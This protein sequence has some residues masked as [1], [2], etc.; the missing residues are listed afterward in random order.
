MPV[1]ADLNLRETCF[2][3]RYQGTDTGPIDYEL[4]QEAL[5]EVEEPFE[6]PSRSLSDFEPPLFPR[7]AA[8]FQLKQ[9]G[10]AKGSAPS[11]RPPLNSSG[12]VARLGSS[13]RHSKTPSL[14]ESASSTARPHSAAPPSRLHSRTTSAASISTRLAPKPVIKRQA[15]PLADFRLPIEEVHLS[16]S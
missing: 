2:F 9:Q 6:L 4:E 1:Y 3:P 7:E 14:Q 15:E 8:L 12:S 16:L 5:A 13:L 10:A 11:V